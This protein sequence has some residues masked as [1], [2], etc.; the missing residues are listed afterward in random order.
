MVLAWPLIKEEPVDCSARC[1]KGLFQRRAWLVQLSRQLWA[2]G[3]PDDY[4]NRLLWALSAV[5]ALTSI[6]VG[7]GLFT[8]LFLWFLAV[9]FVAY[10]T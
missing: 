6:L 8:H 10:D 9:C 2:F 1:L 3:V 7:R 5:L 4:S